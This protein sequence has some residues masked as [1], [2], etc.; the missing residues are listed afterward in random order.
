[1]SHLFP[2][3]LS[4]HSGLI[5]NGATS[6]PTVSTVGY[7]LARLR[8]SNPLA[9]IEVA[10]HAWETPG[11]GKP[12]GTVT[13]AAGGSRGTITSVTPKALGATLQLASPEWRTRRSVGPAI[14]SR[15]QSPQRQAAAL[16]QSPRPPVTA[17]GTALGTVTSVTSPR[18][19]ALAPGGSHLGGSQ[20]TR[21]QSPESPLNSYLDHVY[22]PRGQ[23]IQQQTGLGTVNSV[24]PSSYLDGLYQSGDSH[25]NS[26]DSHFTGER[27]LAYRHLSGSWNPRG[28][29]GTVTSVAGGTGGQSPPAATSIELPIRGQSPY[30]P[31]SSC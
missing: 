13:S 7:T 9:T 12:L 29:T 30:L 28:G 31:L 11:D 25:L 5:Q 8:H 24:T 18:S 27:P 15:G 16:G 20:A 23:S 22:Q 19:L 4:P 17:E 1:M 21:G 10:S 3:D 26:G 14:N 2:I 6:E